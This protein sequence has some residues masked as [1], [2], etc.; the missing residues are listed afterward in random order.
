MF[1][2]HQECYCARGV[3]QERGKAL[4]VIPRGKQRLTVYRAHQVIKKAS[5]NFQEIA[6]KNEDISEAVSSIHSGAI[7]LPSLGHEVY[8]NVFVVSVYAL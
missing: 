4:R 2:S 8:R 5:Q 1:V 6:H 3:T 7:F